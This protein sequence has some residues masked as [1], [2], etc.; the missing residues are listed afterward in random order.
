[1]LSDKEVSSARAENGPVS[2][3]PARETTSEGES[4]SPT[5]TESETKADSLQ[6]DVNDK[7]NDVGH[8]QNKESSS[9]E[10]D[11]PSVSEETNSGSVDE[12]HLSLSAALESNSTSEDVNSTDRT[13]EGDH[14]SE[15][16]VEDDHST[17]RTGTMSPRSF[18][19]FK[20]FLVHT[21][22]MNLP[23]ESM[24]SVRQCN[25]GVSFSYS[26]R[27]VRHAYSSA[28]LYNFTLP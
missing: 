10:D 13:V 15:G 28:M 27:K 4:S 8:C 9:V 22:E 25:C 18:A 16:S 12:K 11:S 26:I 1:M 17:D 14:T 2:D 3:C 20:G 24:R 6:A 7:Q 19:T 5:Q 21:P 23:W